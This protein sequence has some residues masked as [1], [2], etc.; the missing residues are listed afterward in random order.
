[1]GQLEDHY[2][3]DAAFLLGDTADLPKKRAK[4][5]EILGRQ[6]HLSGI[7]P[8]LGAD[9]AG[10][11]PDKTRSASR[12]TEIFFYGQLVGSAVFLAV[13]ALHGLEDDTVFYGGRSDLDRLV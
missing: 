8:S 4:F 3:R 1:M 7:G 2:G 6:H 12:G 13:A 9:G 5:G 11:K 10:L